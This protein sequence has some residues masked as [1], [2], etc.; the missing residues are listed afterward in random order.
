M[1]TTK[2]RRRKKPLPAWLLLSGGLAVGVLT[3]IA[4]HWL[5]EFQW[6]P[7]WDSTE[8]GTRPS[9]LEPGSA[10]RFDFYTILPS[11]EVVVPDRPANT[12]PNQQDQIAPESYY[13]QVGSFR[14]YREADRMKAHVLLLDA[15]ASIE[16]VTLGQDTF[17]RVR[18]GPYQDLPRLR[19]VRARLHR[20]KIDTLLVRARQ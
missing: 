4:Y 7:P 12:P 6:D 14:K 3:V 19:E 5:S 11:Q 13:L 18:I 1:A 16:S 9:D 8:T 20:N 17:H 15:Q 10:T 2:K